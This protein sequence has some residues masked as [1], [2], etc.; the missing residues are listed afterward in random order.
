ME[1]EEVI[2]EPWSSDGELDG[3]AMVNP[4]AEQ[5]QE[6]GYAP[7]SAPSTGI[8]AKKRKPDLWQSGLVTGLSMMA[9]TARTQPHTTSA[10]T[11]ALPVTSTRSFA[12]AASCAAANAIF[13]EG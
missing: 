2:A 10:T 3:D 4:F 12:T 7:V 11:N 5:E 1:E 6:T 9:E 8:A 13:T